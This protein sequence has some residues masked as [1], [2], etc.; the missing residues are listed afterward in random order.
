MPPRPKHSQQG[1]PSMTKK[2]VIVTETLTAEVLTEEDV[3]VIDG[4]EASAVNDVVEGTGGVAMAPGLAMGEGLMGAFHSAARA[5]GD[6]TEAQTQAA[7]LLEAS[8]VKGVANLYTSS[9]VSKKQ[10]RRA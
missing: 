10:A 9:R 2:K 7:T 4:A 6:A 1:I 5:A 3:F 8:T